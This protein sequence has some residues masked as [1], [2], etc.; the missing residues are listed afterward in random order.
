MAEY[1]TANGKKMSSAKDSLSF[2]QYLQAMRLDKKISLEKIS[3][4]TRIALSTLQLI[5]K[6]D[7]DKLPDEV[8][9]KGFL[10]AYAKA[11]GADG[12]E[13]VRRYESSLKVVQKLDIANMDSATGSAR[14]WWKLLLVTGLY[15]MLISVIIFGHNYLE[16]YLSGHISGEKKS[17]GEIISETNTPGSSDTVVQSESKDPGSD[18]HVLNIVVHEDT[19]MKIRIDNGSSTNYELKAGDQLELRAASNFS[20]LIGNAAGVKIK[21]NDESVP[22]SGK[23]GKVVNLDLP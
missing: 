11:I 10:R 23:S 8:F 12:S 5:E 6:E 3:S 7:H 21:L 14:S 16:H 9:V 20:L 17:T 1:K 22:V 19:W 15:L 2:G 18:K 4:E 13:A